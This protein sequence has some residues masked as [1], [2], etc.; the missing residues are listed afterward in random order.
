MQTPWGAFPV[1]DAHVHYFSPA[2][3][4][5]L[6][7]QAGCSLEELGNRLGWRIPAS[8]AELADAWL[9]ELDERGIAQ[10]ALIASLPGDQDSVTAALSLHP[11]RF[12]GYFMAN[13]I[14]PDGLAR[15]EAGLSA[16]LHGVCLFPAMHRYSVCDP[17][18]RPVFE[19]AAARP[20]VVVFVHC[21]VLT[22]GVRQK[23]ALPSPFDMRYSNPLDLHPVAIGFPQVNF[24]VPHFGAGYFREALMLC[25]LCPNVHLD[26]SSTNLGCATRSPRWISGRSSARLWK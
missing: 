15:I 5:A 19:I 12:Y 11:G 23:L 22:V 6:A 21:G 7:A 20:G 3:F 2:F 14:A 16:G 17:R 10:A 1:C 24:V 4:T 18:V 9:Q 13:P 26:T 25:G 8:G